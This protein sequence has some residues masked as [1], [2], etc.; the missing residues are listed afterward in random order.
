MYLYKYIYL[1]IYLSRCA[2]NYYLHDLVVCPWKMH[3][4]HFDLSP[5][6]FARCSFNV[7]GLLAVARPAQEVSPNWLGD[8]CDPMKIR[9][10]HERNYNKTEGA[11]TPDPLK[12]RRVGTLQVVTGCALPLNE[13]TSFRGLFAIR[14]LNF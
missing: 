13:L 12:Y 9:M 7:A 5:W 14:Y 3:Q 1:Y 8:F 10:I 4:G 6:S 2:F 11:S